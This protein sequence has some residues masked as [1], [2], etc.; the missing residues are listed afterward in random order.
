MAAASV[1]AA[2]VVAASVVVAVSVEALVPRWRVAAV[3]AA[4]LVLVVGASVGVAIGL[5]HSGGSYQVAEVTRGSVEA[6]VV[7]VGV[8]APASQVSVVP[9]VSGTVAALNVHVGEAVSQGATLA[10]LDPSQHASASLQTE[11]AALAEA[12][13]ALAEAEDPASQGSDTPSTPDASGPTS[14]ADTAQA[15]ATLCTTPS[16]QEQKACSTLKAALSSQ[17]K[18]D[19]AVTP[20]QTV[21]TTAVADDQAVVAADQAQIASLQ[22]S[23]VASLIAPIT[24]TVASV[25]I[26]Q[27]QQVTPDSSTEAITIIRPGA[28]IDAVPVSLTDAAEL[29]V[30]DG[31]VVEPVDSRVRYRGTVVAIGTTPTTSATTGLTTVQATVQLKDAKLTIFDGVTATTTIDTAQA[32][33]VVVVPT[34]AIRRIGSRMFVDLVTGGKLRPTTVA[35]GVVGVVDTQVTKGLVFGEQVALARLDEPLPTTTSGFGGFGAFGGARAFA[36]RAGRRAFI[37]G[38]SSFAG[39]IP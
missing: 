4:V 28:I 1:A 13:T 32:R 8:L 5:R 37:D 22:T 33:N 21:S 29:R 11:E 12:E 24:G 36:G 7:G 17:G 39:G 20:T 10:T 30:G 31:A 26:A 14:K 19:T 6:T 15:L 38:A 2:S 27:D 3:A 35:T 16:P 25:G 18:G 23:N 34:S 9:S